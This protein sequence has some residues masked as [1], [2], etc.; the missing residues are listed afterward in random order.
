MGKK[1]KRGKKK[2]KGGNKKNGGG[3]A[4]ADPLRR[5]SELQGD[6]WLDERLDAL[7]DQLMMGGDGA[8]HGEEMMRMLFAQVMMGGEGGGAEGFGGM[9]GM[10]AGLAYAAYDDTDD[11][12]E[13]AGG[14]GGKGG[15]LAAYADFD[16]TDDEEEEARE[17]VEVGSFEELQAAVSSS[18]VNGSALVTVKLAAGEFSGPGPLVIT[19]PIHLVGA[20]SAG[21]YEHE[22]DSVSSI[23]K[24]PLH[25]EQ[26]PLNDQGGDLR[27]SS[28]YAQQGGNVATNGFR[29][30]TIEDVTFSAGQDCR[31]DCLMIDA[32]GCEKGVDIKK[33][34]VMGGEDGLFIKDGEVSVRDSEIR[35]AASRG[36]F[37]NPPF[38]I[39]NTEVSNCGSYGIKC[40][41]GYNDL[42][43]CDIQ[44]GPWDELGGGSG[45]MFSGMF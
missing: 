4:T 39:K 34:R 11:E 14:G 29:H 35:F 36:I 17:V 27:I 18:S 15:G 45:G 5:E 44:P 31:G 37:A 7:K 16:D 22:A 13:E 43:G 25:I 33:C 6:D 38:G 10:G 30:I 19:R 41:G 21:C 26:D 12:E 42:G 8:A 2:K 20:G 9:G 3:P 1:G 32:S 23:L 28:L 24:V 40:R